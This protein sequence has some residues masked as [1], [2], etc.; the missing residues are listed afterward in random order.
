MRKQQI[1]KT[2]A[3]VVASAWLAGCASTTDKDA[4]NDG[5]LG[6]GLDGAAAFDGK[7]L[8]ESQKQLLSQRVF[9]FDLDSY[10]LSETDA[11][12]IEA[13]A[14]YLRHYPRTHIRVEGHTDERGSREYNIGLGERRGNTVANALALRGVPRDQI[15][16]VSFGKEKPLALGHDDSAWSQNRRAV[17]HYE[18]TE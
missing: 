8:T 15:S 11:A 18:I 1:L 10:T 12:A 4:L 7:D 3:V 16:V 5:A 2:I 14:Q 17:I 9:Y 13:H 6:S